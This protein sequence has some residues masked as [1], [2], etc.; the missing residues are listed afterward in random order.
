MNAISFTQTHRPLSS[1]DLRLSESL[2]KPSQVMNV[3][4]SHH[5]PSV[6]VSIFDALAEILTSTPRTRLS[7]TTEVT[8]LPL[9]TDVTKMID[10]VSNV[11][12][13]NAAGVPSQDTFN[14]N[15]TFMLTSADVS[16]ITKS[17]QNADQMTPTVIN[18]S[19]GSSV[20]LSLNNQDGN[21]TP[22]NTP[23]TPTLAT[24]PVPIPTPTPTTPIS[25]RRPFA[26]KV[27]YSD[28]ESPT[29]KS[30]TALEFSTVQPTIDSTTVFNTVS[31]LLLSNN[32]LVSS[33]LTS[34]LS[35]NIKNII[36]NMDEDSKSRIS[37]DMAKLLKELVPRALDRLETMMEG[38]DSIPNTT[39][40]SLE[41]IKDTENIDFKKDSVNIDIV[42]NVE[43]SNDVNSTVDNNITSTSATETPAQAVNNNS[44][45]FTLGVTGSTL[46][47]SSSQTT[48]ASSTPI[49]NVIT[50]PIS[51]NIITTTSSTSSDSSG[52]EINLMNN[53]DNLGN[54]LGVVTTESTNK[55]PPLP[56]LTNYRIDDFTATEK[57]ILPATVQ[58][59][60][61]TK[62]LPLIASPSISSL[63][64][65][66][67]DDYQDPSQISRLQ[68]WVLSKKARVLKMIE[69]LIRQHNS[70]LATASPLTD[71]I[72]PTEKIN[73]SER[74]TNIMN[75]MTSSD[76]PETNAVDDTTPFITSPTT[77]VP[78]TTIVSPQEITSSE[79]SAGDLF[80]RGLAETLVP[81]N[82]PLTSNPVD[83]SSRISVEEPVSKTSAEITLSTSSEATTIDTTP[84]F[85]NTQTVVANDVA[86][87]TVTITTERS[88]D[89]N[90]SGDDI[91]STTS[92]IETAQ[93]TTQSDT[94]VTTV[95]TDTI[96]TT[97]L[98]VETTTNSGIDVTTQ[99]IQTNTPLIETNKTSSITFSAAT[100][101][102]PKKDFVIFGILPNNT[103]VRKNPNDDELEQL[104]EATPYI[105]Y[106]V[107]PNN[108]I[109]RKFPNGTRVPR[110][111]Q[112][113]DV[114]PI[115]PWSLRNPYSPIHN[116]P[117]IVRPQ[118]NPI[119]VSTNTVTSTDTSNNGSLTNDTV[120]NQQNMVLIFS[121]LA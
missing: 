51:T 12:V 43:L 56:F 59:I 97:Q 87:T 117:A 35:N 107:L 50:T 118:S 111:M 119:R 19:I 81:T 60:P 104:T 71:F 7:T 120:N 31:D 94:E 20:T 105:V 13:N 48:S 70:E 1:A 72:S 86:T 18:S 8:I 10:G 91:S 42:N 44:S 3:E 103:V 64:N 73:L 38:V 66:E 82:D 113:I 6:T 102:L 25:A 109:I 83:V 78:T 99:D 52:T 9:N 65:V 2:M 28:T 108:T 37:G 54:R 23:Q 79:K 89:L 34:M 115:S 49:V 88:A 41:D 77:I 27:L 110:V 63:Q 29:D 67:D 84:V 75:T 24:S 32:N 96:T 5:S 61:D 15:N 74:L 121:C 93:T 98:N 4:A 46:S 39:P 112:K 58:I 11:N 22:V 14:V 30:T 85:T 36:Q 33:E 26:F 106:G 53:E 47:T 76:S 92:I 45:D 57:S 80:A 62:S 114:L 40:Y 16:T 101:S 90:L 17:V 55:N 21:V 68:L 116:N 95:A 69:D 100:P